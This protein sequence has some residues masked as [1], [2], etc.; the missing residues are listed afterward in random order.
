MAN[1][2]PNANQ[3]AGTKGNQAGHRQSAER[4]AGRSA[5]GYRPA[6]FCRGGGAIAEIP[7]GERRFC[8]RAFSTGI[9]VY[10]A[11]KTPRGAQRVRAGDAAGSENV[12]GRAESGNVVAEGRTCCGDRTAETSGGFAG[13]PEPAT[14]AAWASLR[15][16]RRS[17]ER[18]ERIR[19]STGAGSQG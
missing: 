10:R 16:I 17:Q 4:T 6:K 13:D 2:E 3:Q 7:G 1:S 15:K 12:R 14:H 18:G 11:G 5:E 19:G 8:L 9:C